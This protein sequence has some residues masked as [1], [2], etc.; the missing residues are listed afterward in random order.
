MFE[1]WNHITEIAVILMVWGIG[2]EKCGSIMIGIYIL[3]A[4]YKVHGI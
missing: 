2:G 3:L 1:H 4:Y